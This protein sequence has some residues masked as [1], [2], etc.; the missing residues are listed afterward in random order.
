MKKQIR[1]KDNLQ[2]TMKNSGR[3]IKKNDKKKE[4]AKKVDNRVIGLEYL[5][6]FYSIYLT[7]LNVTF[8]HCLKCNNKICSKCIIS[9]YPYNICKDGINCFLFS[10]TLF[11]LSLSLHLSSLF[12]YSHFLHLSQ[13]LYFFILV[14][15]ISLSAFI[16]VVFK[17][18]NW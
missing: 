17:T 18:Y 14:S 6:K 2:E 13:S 11:T 16:L 10:F 12:Y 7:C 4:K 5:H 9:L 1:D 8:L 15:S 3:K